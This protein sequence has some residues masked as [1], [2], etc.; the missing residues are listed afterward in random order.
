MQKGTEGVCEC[1]LVSL[2]R[3]DQR[4][5]GPSRNRRGEF[6][7]RN[8]HGLFN[9]SVRTPLH[10]HHL[11]DHAF[12]ALSVEFRVVDLLPWAEIQLPGGDRNNNL[13][14]DQQAL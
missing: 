1:Q 2:Q 12:S 13:M 5:Q 10:S 6:Q 7:H 11:H 4:G 14:M 9:N 8:E 3:H